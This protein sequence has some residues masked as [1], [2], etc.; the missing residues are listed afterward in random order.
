MAGT[1]LIRSSEGESTGTRLAAN[2]QARKGWARPSVLR[3]SGSPRV[4]HVPGNVAASAV[5][6]RDDEFAE[7]AA[8][9]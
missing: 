8:T 5:H 3:I 9:V 1:S 2:S 4:D 7:L 6:L